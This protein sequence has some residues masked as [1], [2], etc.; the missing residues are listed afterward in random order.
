M[1]RLSQCAPVGVAV[2]LEPE[3]AGG[4]REA[5]QQQEEAGGD[6]VGFVFHEGGVQ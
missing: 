4:Q 3:H 5:Q 2:A 6:G 1:M